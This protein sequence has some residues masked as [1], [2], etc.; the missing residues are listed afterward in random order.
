MGGILPPIVTDIVN[1]PRFSTPDQDF[2]I[3]KQILRVLSRAGPAP[4]RTFAFALARIAGRG[5]KRPGF[6]VDMEDNRCG[7]DGG[8]TE[9][10]TSER[11]AA[12]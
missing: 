2:I 11:R 4:G 12:A 3:E 9:P 5:G 7:I 1:R 10:E 8:G 6:P